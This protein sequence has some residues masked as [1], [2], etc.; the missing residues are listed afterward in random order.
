MSSK[1][2]PRGFTLVELLVVIAIIALLISILLPALGK[3]RQQANLI[4]CASNLR[5]IGQAVNEYVSDNKGYYPYGFVQDTGSSPWW[6]WSDTLSLMLGQA[7]NP[8]GGVHVNQPLALAAI[9]DDPEVNSYG[10]RDPRSCDYIANTRIF[11]N[12]YLV[13][14]AAIPYQ[15]TFNI[16]TAG[17]VQRPAEVAMVWDNRIQ[18]MGAASIGSQ[19]SDLPITYAME[20]WTYDYPQNTSVGFAFPI[21]Y[22]H[23]YS[24]YARR[25][26]L[27]GGNTTDAG[28][29][30]S[31]LTGASLKGEIYDNVDFTNPDYGG[32]NGGGQYQCEMRFRHMN[33][34]TCNILFADGH[35]SP[36]VI[37]TVTA[38][39]LSVNVNWPVGASD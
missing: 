36:Y 21:P 4:A 32:S 19:D 27:G 1:R 22:Y 10:A 12:Q 29:T 39:M 17:S 2:F 35:V 23:A 25:I 18:M 13:M 38:K 8:A 30:S 20:D 7:P 26:L 16:R 37:G 5:N 33:N 6:Y 11:G 3:A 15:K 24:G 34:T 28:A 9:F 31:S 14:N